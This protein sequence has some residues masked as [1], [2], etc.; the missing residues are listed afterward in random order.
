MNPDQN[1]KSISRLVEIMRRLLAPGGCPWDREQTLESLRT[2]VIE[3]AYEVVDAID[4]GA[5]DALREELGDLLL[6]IVFQAELARAQQWFGLDDVI[7][8]ICD[9]LVRRHPHV[10]ADTE[11]SGSREVILNWEKLKAAERKGNGKGVLDGVPPSLPAL[12]RAMR[13][14]EKA[15]RVGFDWPDA[16]GAR[17]KLDEELGELDRALAAGEREAIG[18]E[19]GD[20]L[21]TVANLARKAKIDPEAALRDTLNRFTRRMRRVEEELESTGRDFA[22]MTPEQLDELWVRAKRKER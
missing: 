20:V 4:K 1:G 9:K 19:L 6:Q 13:V 5:A 7:E 8:S 22:G 16:A 18:R 14:G 10:F 17:G 12:L 3:E 2:Y 15:S 11:V 21:F